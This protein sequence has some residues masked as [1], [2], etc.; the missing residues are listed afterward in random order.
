MSNSIF[1]WSGSIS[2][3]TPAIRG[4]LSTINNSKILLDQR[5]YFLAEIQRYRTEIKLYKGF[6][7]IDVKPSTS[8]NVGI[9]LNFILT[10]T[11]FI[12]IFYLWIWIDIIYAWYYIFNKPNKII[13]ELVHNID[14]R[15][16]GGFTIDLKPRHIR[17]RDLIQIQSQLDSPS[18]VRISRDQSPV[19]LQTSNGKI[20]NN[21]GNEIKCSNCG[22]KC[23]PDDKF[24]QY[25][26]RLLRED[27]L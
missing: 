13:K 23:P 4:S 22:Q 14:R 21:I 25:C 19:I 20:L 3:L 8:I 9:I 10:F 11:L 6:L 12:F 15:S 5:K 1:A 18:P 2:N 7:E 27:L 16:T 17:K 24:C 26:G